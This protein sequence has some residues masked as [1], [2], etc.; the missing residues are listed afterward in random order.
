M[1]KEDKQKKLDYE[2][3]AKTVMTE[4]FNEHYDNYE[5]TKFNAELLEEISAK[6]LENRSVTNFKKCSVSYNLSN[7]HIDLYLPPSYNEHTVRY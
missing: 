4:F 1:S 3:N 2:N 5:I 6:L 7:L